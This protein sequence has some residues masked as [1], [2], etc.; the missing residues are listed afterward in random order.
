MTK[1]IS[2]VGCKRKFLI[3]MPYKPKPGD[4]VVGYGG[5]TLNHGKF[6]SIKDEVVLHYCGNLGRWGYEDDSIIFICS[7]CNSV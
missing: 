5:Q 6:Y 1:N 3:N 2:C 4:V 7:D